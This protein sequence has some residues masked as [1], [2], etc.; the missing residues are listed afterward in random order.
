MAVV[1]LLGP[2]EWD[3]DRSK[4]PQGPTPLDHRRRLAK[5]LEGAQGQHIAFLMEDEPSRSGEDLVEKFWRLIQEKRVTDVVV[6]WPPAAKM[7]TTYDELVL[8]RDRLGLQALPTIWVLH[9]TKVATFERD[10]LTLHEPGGRSRYL[11][12]V[13]RLGVRALDWD[14]DEGLERLAT[15]IAEELRG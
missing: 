10:H 5:L 1:F 8:L 2:S 6:Y 12:A 13:A 9:H 3:P 14:D 4:P 11:E 15:H 7:Q